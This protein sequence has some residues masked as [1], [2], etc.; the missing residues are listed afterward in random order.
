MAVV[1]VVQVPLELQET[2][3]VTAVTVR[4]QPLLEPL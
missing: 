2:P 1:V 3:L 4:H